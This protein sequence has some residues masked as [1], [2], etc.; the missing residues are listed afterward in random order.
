MSKAEEKFIEELNKEHE[1]ILG[2]QEY[3]KKISDLEAKLA[4]SKDCNNMLY[5]CLTEKDIE[6]E[7]QKEEINEWIAV[8]DDKN[9]VIDRQTDKINELKQRLAEKEKEIEEVNREFV[10]STHDWKEIVDEKIK[11]KAEFA[12]QQLEKLRHYIWTN[13]QDDGWLDESVDIYSL[14][15]TIDQII[16]ELEGK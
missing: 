7:T 10:Q 15:E 13:Q 14:N 6:I 2:F 11:A 9:K 4:E 1:I 12:I 5:K 3:E 16:K 8:R